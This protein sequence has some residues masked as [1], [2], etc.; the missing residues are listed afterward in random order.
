MTMTTD[1]TTTPPER[2][3]DGTDNL[4]LIAYLCDGES[5]EYFIANVRPGLVNFSEMELWALAGM[6][7]DQRPEVASFI[8]FYVG[9]VLHVDSPRDDPARQTP[10]GTRKSN[11]C[12]PDPAKVW[13]DWIAQWQSLEAWVQAIDEGRVDT[14]QWETGFAEALDPKIH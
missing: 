10:V 7:V 5:L 3:L 6:F 13:D 12:S 9:A 8:A 11:V 2:V 14:S 4:R 1:T